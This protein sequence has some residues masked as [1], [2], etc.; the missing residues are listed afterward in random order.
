MGKVV[1]RLYIVDALVI[2]DWFNDRE[3]IIILIARNIEEIFF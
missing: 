2:K 3:E 1:E